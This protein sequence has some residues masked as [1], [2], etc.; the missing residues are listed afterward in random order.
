[1]GGGLET[2]TAGA[3][4]VSSNVDRPFDPLCLVSVGKENTNSLEEALAS[5][6]PTPPSHGGVGTPSCEVLCSSLRK[7]GG[8]HL[9]FFYSIVME[10]SNSFFFL[11]S[12]S[13]RVSNSC[14]FLF[15]WTKWDSRYL[16]S[17]SLSSPPTAPTA[18]DGWI[19]IPPHLVPTGRLIK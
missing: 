7:R 18:S 9:L 14:Y 1:M 15:H 5:A 13:M 16:G 19:H 2:V 3:V 17:V 11:E 6:R 10:I 4:K 8:Q 12:F